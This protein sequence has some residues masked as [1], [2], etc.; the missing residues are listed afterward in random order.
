MTQKR[1]IFEEVGAEKASIPPVHGTG[2]IDRN[3]RAARRGLRIWLAVLFA[4]V[5]VTV[6]V[7]GLT[8]L[9]D[10]GL[11]I[12]EWRPV[13]GALPPMSSSAWDAEFAKYQSTPEYQ[14]Q[15]KGMSLADFKVIYW[16][17]W[18]HR[19]LGRFIGVVWAA[20]FLFF[21]VTRRIPA[22]WAGRLLVLGILGGLQGAVGWWMVTSGLVGS[23]V[24]VASYR[25]AAHL[26]MAFLILGL[27]AWFMFDL[28]RPARELM[29]A[30]RHREAG[31]GP[32]TA[33]LVGVAFLQILLGGL[34]AGLD[35]GR[36]YTDWPLMAGGVFPPEMWQIQPWW[37]NLFENDGT[38]QF[39]HRLFGYV[40]AGIGIGVW[41]AARRS[42]HDRTKQMADW[43]AVAICGQVA[44][45]IL[46]VMSSAPWHLALLHQIV[47]VALWVSV[48][49]VRHQVRYPAAQSLEV[50]V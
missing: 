50:S 12:T 40:L 37:R 14:Q 11:S 9:T 18:G 43:M 22:G 46:T 34:V 38:V 7:G 2:I 41:Y 5:A 10:S 48:L 24:D 16:W 1:S 20:G 45:G 30:R 31:L 28:A 4:L 8:R 39:M 32:H 47:A 25:L 13:S 29:Q 35:A 42:G 33:T 3:A 49:L 6:I 23:A 27:I 36:N 44:L 26:G 21:W 17:E 19:Q 15:N